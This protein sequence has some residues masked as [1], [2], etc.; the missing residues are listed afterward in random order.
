MT[1]V[2]Q[3]KDAFAKHFRELA[4]R[5]SWGEPSVRTFP[6]GARLEFVSGNIRV[7]L[8]NDKRLLYAEVGPVAVPSASFTV[9]QMKDLLDPP[10]DGRWSLSLSES[11]EYLDRQWEYLHREF[12][13]GRANATIQRLATLVGR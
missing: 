3:L 13:D 12:A 4:K 10:R 7:R 8:V 5:R 11:A 6:S 9:S 2:D 1:Y